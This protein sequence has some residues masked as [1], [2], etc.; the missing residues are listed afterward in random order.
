MKTVEE[1]IKVMQAYIS[2]KTIKL[3]AWGNP[4]NILEFNKEESPMA[5][6]NWADYDYDIV[7]EPITYYVLID[8]NEEYISHHKLI[9]DAKIMRRGEKRI[10]IAKMI[11]DI[12]FIGVLD[13]E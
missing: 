4:E 13:D 2:G 1:Q 11:E 3:A 7:Q 5:D 10:R 12:S 9:I 8:E 6:F